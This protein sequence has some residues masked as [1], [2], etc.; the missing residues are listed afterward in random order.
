[1]LPGLEA[2]T[3]KI[4]YPPSG[5]VTVSLIG[6]LVRFRFN[7]LS[8]SRAFTVSRSTLW[9][10]LSI[11]TTL[12]GCPWRWKGWLALYATPATLVQFL[13]HQVSINY[14]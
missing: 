14:K 11:P 8:L 5:T 12:N 7:M 13:A 6:G 1:M 3:R 2:C 10:S 9:P 4:V